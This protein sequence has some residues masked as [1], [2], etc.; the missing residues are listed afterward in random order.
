MC[1]HMA[2][3]ADF[4]K[5][6]LVLSILILTLILCLRE[7]RGSKFKAWE[8]RHEQIQWCLQCHT[9]RLVK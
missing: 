2:F 9:R 3:I 5:H 8:L 4:S 7:H 6:H 1:I